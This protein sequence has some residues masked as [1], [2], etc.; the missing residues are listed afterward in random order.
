MISENRWFEVWFTEG[1]ATIPAW[2][3]IVKPDQHNPSQILVYDPQEGYRI[4][5]QG[6]SYEEACLWLGE[7]EYE[8]VDGRVFPDDGLPLATKE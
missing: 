4:V 6:Q 1:G 8:R 2:V 7:D 5:H 3:L